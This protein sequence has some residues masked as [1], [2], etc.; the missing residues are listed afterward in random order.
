V[1]SKGIAQCYAI[2]F[3]VVRKA[4]RQGEVEA[5]NETQQAR[6]KRKKIFCRA[7]CAAQIG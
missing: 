5:G 3:V 4:S 1:G 6:Q 7:V 2:S